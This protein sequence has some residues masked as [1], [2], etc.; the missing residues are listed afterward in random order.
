MGLGS[1]LGLEKNKHSDDLVNTLRKAQV[2]YGAYRPVAAQ[3]RIAALNQGL[4]MFRPVDSM[5][6]RMY[7]PSAALNIPTLQAPQYVGDDTQRRL[8]EI[9]LAQQGVQDSRLLK[10]PLMRKV[11]GQFE[12]A[13]AEQQAQY[14]QGMRL[15]GYR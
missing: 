3:Q 5:L 2:E 1:A 15:G 13:L 11:R 12:K 7:G 14:H 6:Q 8:D 10:S 9:A 4:Q